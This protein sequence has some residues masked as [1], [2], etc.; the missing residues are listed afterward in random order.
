MI[1][2]HHL[3][4]TGYGHW[5]PNDPRGSM[6]V[7]TYAPKLAA[8]ARGHFG[9]KAKQPSL[10]EL[11]AFHRTAERFLA[12]KVL[13]FDAAQRD[14]LA[15]AVGATVRKEKLTCYA[16]AAL[17]DHV[18]LLLRRHRL[19][20]REL[21]RLFREALRARLDA[22]GMVPKGHPVFSADVCVLYKS[23]PR[24][25]RDCARYIQ[26]NFRKHGL[27]PVT[28]DFVSPYDNW[29]FHKREP[30]RR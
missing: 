1:I 16:C 9:R 30:A 10:A 11:R 17:R 25:V 26:A 15:R 12:H 7:E 21:F 6:S 20:G 2:A 19:S 18:H 14:A 13:W 5:L 28:H 29:P 24:A 23:D 27:K 8:L 3:I 22:S 4:L